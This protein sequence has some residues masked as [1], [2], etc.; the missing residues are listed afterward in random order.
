MS[1]LD[2]APA[3]DLTQEQ[4]D[5]VLGIYLDAF[6]PPLRVPFAELLS[7]GAADLMLVA[8][9]GVVPAGF[10]S[11]RLL[12]SA[13]W[14][15]LRYF[16]IA[17]DRRG[18]GAG[19]QLW[20]L[21]QTSVLAT[22]WAA[23]I[24]FEVE[25]PGE[26]AGDEAERLVRR[27]RLAFWSGCGASLLPVPGYVLPDYTGYGRTE[28]ILLMASDPG[29]DASWSPDELRSL[30]LAI[31]TERYGLGPSDPLVTA[32]LASIDR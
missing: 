11:L 14:T 18:Q 25:D 22:R 2:V 1:K 20:R 10:A 27:R 13:S 15:F 21:V 29:H 9:D 17:A 6:P 28:P 30:V 32:A 16:A 23:R 31:Y 12:R 3:G 19:Q 8:L 4:L 5:Q 26:V 24:V 7:A